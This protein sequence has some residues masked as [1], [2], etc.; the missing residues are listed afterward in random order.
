MKEFNIEQIIGT[1]DFNKNKLH[2]TKTNLYLKTYEIEIL[3]KYHIN[4]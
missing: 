2:K 4:Y 3:K 1:I